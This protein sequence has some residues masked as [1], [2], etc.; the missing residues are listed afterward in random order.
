MPK[1]DAAQF[2]FLADY[3]L[4]DL[5]SITSF[6]KLPRQSSSYASHS[7]TSRSLFEFEK[8]TTTAAQQRALV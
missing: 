6:I 4:I 2:P 3:N 1:I 7:P 5:F 8:T